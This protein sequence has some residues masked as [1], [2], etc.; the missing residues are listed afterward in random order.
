MCRLLPI[1]TKILARGAKPFG[2]FGLVVGSVT[3][4]YQHTDLAQPH[5]RGTFTNAYHLAWVKYTH[6]H[7]LQAIDILGDS[8]IHISMAW[9]QCAVKHK[10]FELTQQTGPKATATPAEAHPGHGIM[11][12]IDMPRHHPTG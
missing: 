7:I 6:E 5:P 1:L 10:P 12:L 2:A 11:F 8:D 9:S 3:N 4:P